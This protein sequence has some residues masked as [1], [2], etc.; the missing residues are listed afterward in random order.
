MTHETQTTKSCCSGHASA[1]APTIHK[2]PVC[3]MTVD[4]AT[5]RAR[6][7]HNGTTIYFCC[8]GCANKFSANPAAYQ[9]PAQIEV[10]LQRA[11]IKASTVSTASAEGYTC[12]MHPEVHSAIPG[13]CPDCGMPLE[14]L[15]PSADDDGSAEVDNCAN[16]LR[17][18][19]T[20]T[21]P[22]AILSMTHMLG[23][24]GTAGGIAG[25]S[26]LASCWLQFLLATPV[27]VWA[28]LPFFKRGVSSVRNRSLNM[29]T[30][31]SL[32]IG[33]PYVYSLVSLIVVSLFQSGEADQHMVYFESAGVIT[34]LAWLGQ[35]LEAKARVRSSSAVR[36][37]VKLMPSTATVLGL[38]GSEST[39]AV[40]DI[41]VDAR[42]RVRPGECVPVDG[43]VL[44]GVSSVDESMLTGEPIPTGKE[45]GSE[46]S[47]G[48]I[49]GTGSLI[50]QAKRIGGSTLLSQIVNLVSQAQR[51]RVPAQQLADKVSA[52]FV[53]AVILIALLTLGGWWMAGAGVVAA[54]SAAV[55]VLVV[56]CP[57][58]LGLATP[59]SIVVAAGRAA[60]AGVLFKEARS[61][62]LLA[63]VDTVVLD[64]TGTLT[65]GKPK[66]VRTV[67][68]GSLPEKELLALAASVEAESEHPLAAAV[69]AAFEGTKSGGCCSSKSGA[70]MSACK[71]FSSKPGAGI[72][73]T[74]AGRVVVVGTPAYLG[75]L[76]IDCS[77]LT[78]ADAGG[79]ETSVFVGVDGQCEGRLDFADE[80]R[81]DVAAAVKELQQRG[82]RVVIA[83]G[84]NI[85]AV[86]FVGTALGVKDVHAS[87][88]PA[89]KAALVK[90]LQSQGAKV[91]MAGDGVNDAPALV[92]ADVGIAMA[93][94]TDIAVHSADIVLVNSDVHGVVRAHKV[95]NAM[96]TNIRQNLVLAFGY[97]LIAI[98]VATGVL[99]HVIGFALD[100]MVAA[101]AMS[102]SS[103]AVIANALRLRNLSL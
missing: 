45:V 66:L 70:G 65:Q 103:V 46:V 54:L 35:F 82:M 44:E 51:S 10:R 90:E 72:R 6:V 49:N 7:E 69:L 48:T 23:T 55:A 36:D 80:L 67:A 8:Q 20:L 30:L 86:Q 16:R 52:I 11:S 75:E 31:L 38:D 62:Q 77:K 78:S 4:P 95:S 39:V 85:R 53:P 102:V 26:H 56:A 14:P 19:A 63:G 13:D 2:D 94:G 27:V 74:V 60:R 12:P 15:M 32:G 100:P 40:A 87:L 91:A 97:N 98:P 59:M 68:T 79:Y 96:V 3:G 101:A 18:S 34:T 64:K 17:W 84:D 5:A 71:D 29:F 42:V 57:C 37:L 43:I 22:L 28:A 99:A 93:S 81:P 25:L 33:I 89:D 21:V 47:A 24:G 9:E 73:G 92:Q 76:G 88:L 41:S 50:V 83:S 58:A 61:L 1:P